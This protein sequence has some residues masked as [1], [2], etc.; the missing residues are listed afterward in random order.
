MFRL[1]LQGRTALVTGGF[2]GLGLHFAQVLAAQGASV[3]LAGRRIEL[4]REVAQRIASEPGCAG[5]CRA[6]ALDVTAAASVQECLQ[7]VST[8]LGTPDVLINNAGTAGRGPSLEVGESDWAQVIDVNLNGVFRVAQA[9][10][11][12][13]LSAGRG[14]SIVNIA[15]IL[16]LRV[17][18]QAAAYAA[19]KAAVVQLTKALALEWAPYGIR[20]N[21]I[22][23][24]YFETDLNREFLAS[25][26]G[27]ELVAR[28]PQRRVGEMH[29][30]DGPLLLLASDASAY[31]TGSVIP[32]DGGHL[33]NTL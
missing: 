17:R 33:V 30:L 25:P 26:T 23:P 8:E 12:T 1:D 9:T 5:R 31:M 19:S 3:A 28:I 16:G 32:V 10:A 24:G 20:V 18:A 22:A 27:R 2:S 21:A 11:R 4:G 6:Y 15:S 7:R 29:E 14:G 13:M